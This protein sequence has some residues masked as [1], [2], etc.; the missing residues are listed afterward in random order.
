VDDGGE[1]WCVDFGENPVDGS[2][3]IITP[4]DAN[5]PGQDLLVGFRDRVIAVASQPE[6]SQCL[7]VVA[8]SNTTYLSPHGIYK[9]VQSFTCSYTDPYQVSTS[10]SRGQA[11]V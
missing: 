11:L 2:P 1:V 4:C 10:T 7:D 6:L 8:N 9:A 5:A 3:I